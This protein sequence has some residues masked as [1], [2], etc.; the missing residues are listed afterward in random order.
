MQTYYR[1]GNY[2]CALEDSLAVLQT[3]PHSTKALYRAGLSCLSLG[4]PKDARLH[5]TALHSQEGAP[6][7]VSALLEQA[8][9]LQQHHTLMEA[10]KTSENSDFADPAMQRLVS[11]LSCLQDEV[12][13]DADADI[14]SCLGTV[15]SC[16]QA[17]PHCRAYFERSNGYRLLWYFFTEAFCADAANVLRAAGTEAVLWPE[18]EW[19]RLLG[20]ALGKEGPLL[21]ASALELVLWAAEVNLVWVRRH[22]MVQPLPGHPETVPLQQIVRALEA[23]KGSATGWGVAAVANAAKLLAVYG[24]SSAPE[25]AKALSALACRPLEALI[26]AF[27]AAEDIAESDRQLAVKAGKACEPSAIPPSEAEALEKLLAKR[28]AVFD[29]QVVALQRTLLCTLCVLSSNRDLVMAEAVTSQRVAP[30]KGGKK[31]QSGPLVPAVASMLR[32]LVDRA[33]KR[34][35]PVLGPDGQPAAYTK[36]PFAADYADNPT[37]DFLTNLDLGDKDRN[38]SEGGYGGVRIKPAARSPDVPTVGERTLL[39]LGLEVGVNVCGCAAATGVLAYRNNMLQVCKQLYTFLTPDI[40][41][42]G[43]RLCVAM[44]DVCPAAWEETLQEGSVMALAGA[45][46]YC[47]DTGKVAAALDKLAGLVDASSGDDFAALTGHDGIIP[48]AVQFAT[49]AQSEPVQQPAIRLLRLCADRAVRQQGRSKGLLPTGGGWSQVDCA[50]LRS[51]VTPVS[52]AQKETVEHSMKDLKKGFLGG[53]AQSKPKAKAPSP[54]ASIT[55]PAAPHAEPVPNSKVVYGNG[56]IIEELLDDPPQPSQPPP[57]TRPKHT[58]V[59][60]TRGALSATAAN[61][62]IAGDKEELEEDV[63]DL[64]D[65]YDSTPADRSMRSARSTWLGIKPAD[66]YRWSQTSTDISAWVKV[67]RGTKVKELTVDVTPGKLT[68]GLG[69][70]GKIVDKTL[71]AGVKAREATW[72]LVDDEIHVVLPKDGQDQW[73]KALFQGDEEKGYYQLLQ[74]AVDAGKPKKRVS[75]SIFTF[76]KGIHALLEGKA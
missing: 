14:P 22:L 24:S 52:K 65:V 32:F 25:A 29:A 1:L 17:S 43:Q 36:R 11:A 26:T 48:K 4:K 41:R 67:P 58:D 73:W 16:L 54:A 55:T 47:K 23:S 44:C 50:T 71:F 10:D 5:F 53:L 68:V 70:F 6:S 75:L 76:F 8:T 69:W 35:A 9:A 19:A 18:Q 30:S 72:C 28:R 57:D 61:Q 27:G 42:Q 33:P 3:D 12:S 38:D 46:L 60:D 51:F 40:V 56:V 66:R 63:P 62:S 21:A 13:G 2:A 20:L 59:E 45:V 34:T 74:D 64:A 7:D 31:S 15:T 39:E 37:G 49:V